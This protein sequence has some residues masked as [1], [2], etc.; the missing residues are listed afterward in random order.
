ME[1]DRNANEPRTQFLGVV[2]TP[3]LVLNH[4]QKNMT[5]K[6]VFRT[7]KLTNNS[8]IS[9]AVMHCLRELATP[10]AD[11][12][13]TPM[14]M[15]AGPGTKD[16]F[17][18]LLDKRIEGLVKRSTSVKVVEYLISAS[19]EYF[20]KKDPKGSKLFKKSLD[21]LKSTHGAENVLLSV[22]HL[23]EAT[24]H[25]SAFVVPAHAGKLNAKHFLGG[26]KKLSDLQTSCWSACGKP[27]GIER[28]VIGSLARHMPTNTWKHHQAT[29]IAPEALL[30]LPRLTF[31]DRLNP[32]GWVESAWANAARRLRASQSQIKTAEQKATAAKNETIRVRLKEQQLDK[33]IKKKTDIL[34]A[35]FALK[36]KDDLSDLARFRE[37][38]GEVKKM[39]HERKEL[40]RATA[41]I[42]KNSY[43]DI[44]LVKL[45]TAL[46]IP[47]PTGKSDIFDA[48]Q[49]AGQAE[50]FES[51][52]ILVAQKINEHS[53]IKISEVANWSLDYQAASD[54]EKTEFNRLKNR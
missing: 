25:L 49:K 51:A 12:S 9:S 15:R 46:N 2:S 45:C 43:K 44:E 50:N 23:D 40:L 52:V 26:R 7:A 20:D 39:A 47:T 42:I 30:T 24:P 31:A 19:P 4:T 48:I 41:L 33:I 13:R 36:L 54:A 6:F 1:Y 22:V 8:A 18:Q 10:N 37:R 11:S 5:A 3:S 34:F 35:D 53:D 29:S 16:E 17:V 21:W 14:N 38:D 32:R 27:L 28:G